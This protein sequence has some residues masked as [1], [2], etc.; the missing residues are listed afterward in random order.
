M[1]RFKIALGRREN[2]IDYAGKQSMLL[3]MWGRAVG[4]GWGRRR[5]GGGEG[6]GTLI[7]GGGQ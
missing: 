2:S 4:R 1:K 6:E 3:G 5:D 7:W